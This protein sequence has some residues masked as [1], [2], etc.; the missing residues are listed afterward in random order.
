VYSYASF[1]GEDLPG[2]V[3][4]NIDRGIKISDGVAGHLS[5]GP[6][7]NLSPGD[8]CAGF[9]IRCVD[10]ISD[11]KITID[12]CINNGVQQL[13]RKD[14]L[15]SELIGDIPEFVKVNFALEADASRLEV[16]LH[17][18]E[19]IIIEIH[20]LVIFKLAEISSQFER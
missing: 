4:L 18:S 6:Y 1:K 15:M 9:Y 16:R 20:E 10:H 7:I 19:K 17:V 8:Y 12:V 13:L 3:G 5:Y 11:G 14:I 2:S